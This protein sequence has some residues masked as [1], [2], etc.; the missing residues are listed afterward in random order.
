ML[1]SL[2][3]ESLEVR[4]LLGGIMSIHGATKAGGAGEAGGRPGREAVSTPAS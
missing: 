4:N 3:I 2:S 1:N